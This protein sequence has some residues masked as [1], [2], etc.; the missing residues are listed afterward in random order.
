MAAEWL[1]AQWTVLGTATSLTTILGLGQ[2]KFFSE[3]HVTN[4]DASVNPVYIGGST[5]TNVPANAYAKVNSG[6]IG[7]VEKWAP[8]NGCKVSTDAV[9][10]VGTAN[11]ANVAFV[12]IIA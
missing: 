2:R 12:S 8:S 10:L 7:G 3:L 1:G 6:A 9:F 11:A 4:A 5:V